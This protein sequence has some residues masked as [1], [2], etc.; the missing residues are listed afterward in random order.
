MD[1]IKLIRGF[2]ILNRTYLNYLSKALQNKNISYSDS[3]FL[4]NIGENQG[5]NQENLSKLLAID[6]AAVARSVKNM[7]KNNYIKIENSVNDNRVKKLYLTDNGKSI[8]KYILSLNTK[9]IKYV[10]KDLGNDEI[11]TLTYMINTISN[12]SKEYF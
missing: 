1:E 10:M 9:W 4:V 2:G 6:K 11:K 3:I 8:Y 5:L 7:V 12:K